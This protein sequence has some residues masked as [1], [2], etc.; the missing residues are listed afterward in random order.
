MY[1]RMA[2][3]LQIFG[4]HHEVIQFFCYSSS[5]PDVLRSSWL[6]LHNTNFNWSSCMLT[7]LSTFCHPDCLHSAQG[8]LPASTVPSSESHDLSS[9]PV[10]YHD[11]AE[12]FINKCALSLPPHQPSDC[13]INLLPGDDRR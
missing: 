7:G 11:L 9:V 3:S 12:T 1:Q 8:S 4:N 10:K 6:R 5:S 13:F 2:L